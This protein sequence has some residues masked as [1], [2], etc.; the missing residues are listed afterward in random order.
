[1]FHS[2]IKE[3][4]S[5]GK[6]LSITYQSCIS[7]GSPE[8]EAYHCFLRG[9][10]SNYDGVCDSLDTIDLD[11]FNKILEEVI[12]PPWWVQICTYCG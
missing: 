8:D 3:D 1:M 11:W 6:C 5:F 7:A 9:L 4:E 2:K 10:D 12:Q